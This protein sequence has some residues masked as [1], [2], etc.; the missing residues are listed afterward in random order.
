MGLLDELRREIAKAMEEAQRQAEAAKQPVPPPSD[1]A[2]RYP[3]PPVPAPQQ[4]TAN[5]QPI[6]VATG[7]LPLPPAKRLAVV[8]CMDTRVLV[9]KALNLRTGDAHLLRN[10]GG[11]VTDDVLR[12]L[13]LSHHALGVERVVVIGHTECGL[14]AFGDEE[15]RARIRQRMGPSVNPPRTF[16]TF[17]D[18]EENVREQMRRV[19]ACPYLPDTLALSGFV[20]ELKTGRLNEVSLVPESRPSEL[21]PSATRGRGVPAPGRIGGR[22]QRETLQRSTALTPVEPAPATGVLPAPEFD[23]EDDGSPASAVPGAEKDASLR[24]SPREVLRAFVLGEVMDEP[25]GRKARRP[26]PK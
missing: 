6:A 23:L 12:S 2:P 11:L 21:L 5:T 4:Q 10:A 1:L 18:L 25:K 9:E 13:A 15:L 20:Y 17:S 16:G 22:L 26:H 14:M 24:F 3:A 8:T 7:N 19:R